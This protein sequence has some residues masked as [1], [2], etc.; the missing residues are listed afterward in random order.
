[1]EGTVFVRRY[2]A[3][4]LN[5]R[6]VLRYAGAGGS[7]GD[8][9]TLLEEVRQEAEG[10]LS[11]GVCHM[12]IPIP[13]NEELP[14]PGFSPADSAILRSFLPGCRSTVL[15]AATVGMEFDRL[16]ARHTRLSPA[17][18]LLLQALGAERIEALC[19][20]FC[21]EIR[22]QAEAQGLHTLPRF[23]PGYG[24]IPL[25]LQ[26]NIFRLLDC[27]RKIGLTLNDSLLMS[28]SKSVTAFVGIRPCPAPAH[29]GHCGD[30]T[31]ADCAYRR[32]PCKLQ[33]I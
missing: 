22:C 27:P 21:E 6:E 28:P 11:Y 31:K 12:E 7:S 25:T 20:A 18:A 2:D 10:V 33:N 29:S 23:S 1:M 32:K 30:C 13:E 4:P 24:S 15:F 26:R 8:L 14:V 5:P 16:L 17:R 9:T 19:D 3:P